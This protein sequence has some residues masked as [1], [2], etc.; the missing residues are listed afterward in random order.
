MHQGI[1]VKIV[2]PF[3]D[4]KIALPPRIQQRTVIR[5]ALVNPPG[6]PTMR[7][8]QAIFGLLPVHI[9]CFLTVRIVIIVKGM[10]H[11]IVPQDVGK[12]ACCGHFV[13]G[14]R[15]FRK[16]RPDR[17]H[18]VKVGLMQFIN[19]LFWV[20]IPFGPHHM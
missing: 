7:G 13:V 6:I 9:A 17:N 14:L 1:G 19:H 5:F 12:V 20:R 18:G 11:Y 4:G 2:N 8:N 3:S 10:R 16:N 15:P